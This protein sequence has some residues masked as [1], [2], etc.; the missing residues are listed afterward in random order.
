MPTSRKVNGKVLTGDLT[1]SADDI[2]AANSIKFYGYANYCTI[3]IPLIPKASVETD[4]FGATFLRGTL[5][6]SRGATGA[7]NRIETLLLNAQT[8]YNQTH[9]SIQKVTS[10]AGWDFRLAEFTYKGTQWLGLISRHPNAQNQMYE[11]IGAAAWSNASGYDKA[12]QFTVIPVVRKNDPNNPDGVVNAEINDSLKLWAVEYLKDGE[13]VTYVP[14][15][16]KIND[17]LLT[18]DITLSAADV[19]AL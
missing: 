6:I 10:I 2:G 7:S 16:R 1:L 12:D 3:A 5:H 11:F 18:S 9:A 14:G 4:R 17:R 13:N 19:G 15:S 8:A